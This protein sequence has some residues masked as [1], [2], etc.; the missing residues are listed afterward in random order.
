MIAMDLDDTLLMTDLTIPDDVTARLQDLMG[1]GV[2][3]TLATGRMFPSAKIYADRLGTD[4]LLVTYNGA[5]VRSRKDGS[6]YFSS[7]VPRAS[8][9][10]IIRYCK[11]R[12]L[13]LQMY[14]ND[15]IV[16]ERICSE[17]RIDPDLKNAQCVEVGNFNDADLE[18]PPKMMIVANEDE[19]MGIRGELKQ[20]FGESLYI[21]ASKPYLVEIM[22][23][24]ISKAHA[25]EMLCQHYGIRREEVICCGDSSN[26]LEMVKWAGPGVCMANGTPELKA[27]ADYV[28][29]HERSSGIVEVINKFFWQT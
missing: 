8:V 12:K 5:V 2:I 13:Y 14:A 15:K 16:V 26:D 18:E 29:Y 25:L 6:P 7:A 4:A 21:A 28:T 10:K 1:Q 20:L 17:T 11:E 22:K 9:E 19:V 27:A 24:G 3:V 23:A